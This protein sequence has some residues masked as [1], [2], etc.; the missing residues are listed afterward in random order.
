MPGELL[1]SGAGAKSVSS[2]FYNDKVL[3]R[4]LRP[5]IK[6]LTIPYELVAAHSSNEHWDRDFLDGTGGRIVAGAPINLVVVDGMSYGGAD[7]TE[8]FK[9]DAAMIT[10]YSRAPNR[11]SCRSSSQP[12]SSW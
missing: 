12:S 10:K 7:E 9:R 6:H 5:L 11:P 4:A 2:S 8:A 1:A 3:I